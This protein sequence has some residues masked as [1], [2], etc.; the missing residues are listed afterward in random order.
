[1]IFSP[2]HSQPRASTSRRFSSRAV[3]SATTVPS[4]PGTAVKRSP[5]HFLVINRKGLGTKNEV[6]TLVGYPFHPTNANVTATIDG[7]TLYVLPARGLGYDIDLGAGN[8]V[9]HAGSGADSIRG[10]TGNDTLYGDAGNDT[11]APPR[12]SSTSAQVEAL[13]KGVRI[14]QELGLDK[15]YGYRVKPLSAVAA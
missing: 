8:D 6:Q 15:K 7:K 2:T 1:M 9:V 14:I 13:A 11:F 4:P 3:I 10:G 12:P 5:I